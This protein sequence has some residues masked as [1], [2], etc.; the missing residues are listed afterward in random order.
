MAKK[1]SLSKEEEKIFLTE[2]WNSIDEIDNMKDESSRRKLELLA[3]SILVMLDGEKAFFP[4]FAVRPIDEKGKEGEDIAGSLHN[5]FHK[6][7]E[8]EA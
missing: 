5:N 6:M 2:I 8:V 7:Q 1:K 3:F 4:P